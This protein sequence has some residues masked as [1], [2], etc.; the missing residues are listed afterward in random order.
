ML[1]FAHLMHSQLAAVV[2]FLHAVPGPS[3][4]EE[5]LGVRRRRRS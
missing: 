5:E 4:E 1:V 2:D 3:G